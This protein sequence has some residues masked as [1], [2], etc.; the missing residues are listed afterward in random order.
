[1]GAVTVARYERQLFYGSAGSTAAIQV[2]TLVEV[3]VNK[4][5]EYDPTDVRGDG[6]TIPIKTEH[7]VM[8]SCELKFKLRNKKGDA[9]TAALIAAAVH[10]SNPIIALKVVS[11]ASGA[12]LFDG[13]VT[14]DVDDPDSREL[15]FTA[16]C[17]LEG[18]R[19]PSF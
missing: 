7:P 16:H 17:S 5:H 6:T 4:T 15:E 9:P 14:L 12:V 11:Y 19:S 8:R 18:G 10:V 3:S 1:M 13:D 2:L